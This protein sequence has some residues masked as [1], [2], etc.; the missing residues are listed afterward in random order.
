VTVVGKEK[1]SHSQQ[2]EL[3]LDLIMGWYIAENRQALLKN[4][5]V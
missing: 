1:Y 5:N 3:N 2:L 4:D